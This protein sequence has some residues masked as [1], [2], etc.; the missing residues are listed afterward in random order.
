MTNF[1]II[2]NKISSVQKYLSILKDY[3]KYS[4]EE[5]E[6]DINLK[7]AL[8]RYLYLAIQSSI[9][10]SEAVISFKELR[11]PSSMAESFQILKENKIINNNLCENLV[12]MTGF[13]NIMVHDYEKINYDI[14]FDVLKNRLGDIKNFISAVKKNLNLKIK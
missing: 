11:K 13:R 6:K 9:D 7:G 8:E 5:I 4:K 12:K 2:E 10:L 1:S 3:K 14:V